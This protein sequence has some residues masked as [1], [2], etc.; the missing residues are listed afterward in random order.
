[1]WTKN[2]HIKPDKLKLIEK[3]VGKSLEHVGTGENFPNRTPKVY[4]LRLRIDNCSMAAY[5]IAKLL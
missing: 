1:M 5:K 3:K 4:A 2:F